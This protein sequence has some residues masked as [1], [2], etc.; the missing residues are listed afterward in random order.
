MFVSHKKKKIMLVWIILCLFCCLCCVYRITNNYEVLKCLRKV[1]TKKIRLDGF[2][3]FEEPKTV[4]KEDSRTPLPHTTGAFAPKMSIWTE[5]PSVF[6]P[7]GGKWDTKIW[8][9]C[10][11]RTEQSGANTYLHHCVAPFAPVLQIADRAQWAL[12][13]TV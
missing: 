4:L 13:A 5:G 7:Q 1:K 6:V 8:R 9:L 11:E 12:C 2:E 3:E 10:A